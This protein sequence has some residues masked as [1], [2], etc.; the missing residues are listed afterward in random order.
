MGFLVKTL[1]LIKG[2]DYGWMG[3]IPQTFIHLYNYYIYDQLCNE[4]VKFI[5]K[6]MW[7]TIHLYL[8]HKSYYLPID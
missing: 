3:V 4:V 1:D 8:Y 7:D 5:K 6:L 2:F